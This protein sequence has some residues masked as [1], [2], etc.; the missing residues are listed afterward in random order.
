[1]HWCYH[2]YGVN[3]APSGPCV[4]CGKE[5][6]PPDDLSYDQRLIWALGHPDGDRAI[7]AARTLG[8]HRAREAAPRLEEVASAGGDPFLAAEALRSLVAIEGADALRPFLTEIAEHG[9]LLPATVAAEAL[10]GPS[11]PRPSDPDR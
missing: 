7:M 1:M 11:P 8:A 9:G 4:R 3:Q 6:A 2:C 5:I 10:R